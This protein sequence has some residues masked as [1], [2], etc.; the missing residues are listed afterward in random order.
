MTE[1]NI[2]IIGD[3]QKLI[4]ATY[5]LIFFFLSFLSITANASSISC[6]I[7]LLSNWGTGSQFAVRVSNLTAAPL[8]SWDMEISLPSGS[9]VFNSWTVTRQVDFPDF[10]RHLKAS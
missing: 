8:D 9:Q 2:G 4:R 1:K 10:T 5:A 3:Y 7:S 6:Q